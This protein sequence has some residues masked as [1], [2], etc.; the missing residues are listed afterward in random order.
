MSI[1][2][3]HRIME[4]I[5]SSSSKN[6]ADDSPEFDEQHLVLLHNIEYWLWFLWDCTVKTILLPVSRS[7]CQDVVDMYR[8]YE[9]DPQA[10]MQFGSNLTQVQ[11]DLEMA[12]QSMKQFTAPDQD[13]ANVPVFVKGS[14]RS[15]KDVSSNSDTFVQFYL[16]LL[17]ST[18]AKD[19]NTKITCLLKAQ[20]ECMKVY[21]AEGI[22]KEMVR[23]RRVRNDLQRAFKYEI[24]PQYIAVREF[25]RF[26]PFLEFR[27]FVWEGKLNGLSQYHQQAFFPQ[28]L[29][30]GVKERIEVLILEMFDRIRERLEAHFS[31]CVVD[32]GITCGEREQF[33][34]ESLERALVIEL[35]P[36]WYGTDPCLFNWKEHY[37][38]LQNGPFEFRVLSDPLP[39]SKDLL[40][41]DVWKKL[42]E[43]EL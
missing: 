6:G 28:L 41:Y 39:N 8:A 24:F 20:Q 12:V 11:K 2:L 30:D 7:A 38:Q 27:G 17:A 1:E 29:I 21:S 26:E 4:G 13:A 9:T 36:F 22:L 40:E 18:E 32:F 3:D 16:K 35:N 10:S 43:E 15:C 19:Q 31:C 25:V 34:K 37:R 14:G 23:S 5:P 33:G 42:L